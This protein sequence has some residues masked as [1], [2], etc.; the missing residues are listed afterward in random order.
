MRDGFSGPWVALALLVSCAST[1]AEPAKT[2]TSSPSAV[3]IKVDPVTRYIHISYAVPSTVG[4]EAVVVCSW[5]PIGKEE[6]RPARVMPDVSET[7]LNLVQRA[8][9]DQWFQGRVV[10]RRAAGLM[11]TLIFRP[12]PDAEDK[13]LVNVDFRIQIESPAVQ[14]VDTQQ[15]KVMAD[16]R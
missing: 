14:V 9:W 2:P 12:Y 5:S 4:E 10:E 1:W 11:R 6:W 13:G 16:N 3:A 7:G 8:E 15:F